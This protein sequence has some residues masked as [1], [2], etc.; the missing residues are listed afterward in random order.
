MLHWKL[1]NNLLCLY[2]GE[3]MSTPNAGII[4][5]AEFK[6]L[7]KVADREIN[8]PSLDLPEIK[9][10]KFAYDIK[11]RL[12]ISNDAIQL[13]PIIYFEKNEY[14]IGIPELLLDYIIIN[15]NWL[16]YIP[17]IN[18]EIANALKELS[19]QTTNI[20]DKQALELKKLGSLEGFLV[21]DEITKE[22]LLLDAYLSS[23]LFFATLLQYQLQGFGW[24]NFMTTQDLGIV[25]ADE[26]GLGKTVQIIRLVC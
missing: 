8:K 9:F 2:N 26:M 1:D 18:I 20:T 3:F 25:L 14:Q 19:I 4:F 16:P 7:T 6:N 11:I 5:E 17:D 15:N 10:S 13:M 23:P 24:M 12:N 21:E 22:K